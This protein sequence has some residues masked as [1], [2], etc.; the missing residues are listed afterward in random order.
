VWIWIAM[1]YAQGG[2]LFD[3]IGLFQRAVYSLYWN[4]ILLEGVG[5]EEQGK[6]RNH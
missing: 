4:I 2:D 5:W 3:K 1:E 6:W